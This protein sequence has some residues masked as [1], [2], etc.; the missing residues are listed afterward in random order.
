MR[1]ESSDEGGVPVPEEQAE[2]L[3]AEGQSVEGD[4][5]ELTDIGPHGRT[6]EGTASEQETSVSSS[7]GGENT[8]KPLRAVGGLGVS[9]VALGVAVLAYRDAQESDPNLVP[10]VLDFM[11]KFKERPA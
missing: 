6:P 8:P 9:A 2:A 11:G 5:L 1:N 4:H 10:Q 7:R 3:L